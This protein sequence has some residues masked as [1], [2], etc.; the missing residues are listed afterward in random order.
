[1]SKMVIVLEWSPDMG[2]GWMNIDNLKLCLFSKK[3][4]NPDL[5]DVQEIATE[6]D[7]ALRAFSLVEQPLLEME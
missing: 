4:T 2:K 7:V 3:H 1:M 6:D 5:I